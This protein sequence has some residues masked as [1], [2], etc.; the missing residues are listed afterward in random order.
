MAT[1]SSVGTTF[2]WW[3]RAASRASSIIVERNSGSSAR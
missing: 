1:T 3:M 2:G